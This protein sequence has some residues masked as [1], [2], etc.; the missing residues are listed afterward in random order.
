MSLLSPPMI[1]RQSICG[2]LIVSGSVKYVV[3]DDDS[4]PAIGKE[5]KR[6]SAASAAL[7]L[8]PLSQTPPRAYGQRPFE[9]GL[10]TSDWPNFQNAP[11]RGMTS[12]LPSQPTM[13]ESQDALLAS[14][15]T[16]PTGM[17]DSI[18]SLP[19]MPS[20][21]V[22]GTPF[23]LG[24][25][26]GGIRRSGTSP[27][28]NDGLSQA[29]RGFSNPDLARTFG[30]AGGFSTINDQPR[31]QGYGNDPLYSMFGAGTAPLPPN[32]GGAQAFHPQGAFDPYG[33]DDDGYGSGALY[34]GG[35]MGLKNK[36]AET[37]RECEWAILRMEVGSELTFSQPLRRCQD[38]G[39]AGRATEPVQRSA[40]LPIPAEEARGWRCRSSRYDF[41]RDVRPFPRT[42]DRPFRQLPLPEAARVLDRG[43][44]NCYHRVC[45]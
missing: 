21:S 13:A 23:G 19:A 1:P 33:F 32:A 38:R 35:A 16:S 31:V 28:L 10:K 29:Q 43:A 12:P 24:N 3:G 20:K 26:M 44:A 6:L 14:R 39:F 27:K 41:P 4:F 42:H 36:R 11:Q 9:T 25:G 22:P 37:D 34:S 18:A 2:E 45:F 8:A 40:W 15:K 17:G 5:P 30:K 7:D